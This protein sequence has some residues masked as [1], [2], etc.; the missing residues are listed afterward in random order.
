[1]NPTPTKTN[2]QASPS[3]IN[4]PTPKIENLTKTQAGGED[5]IST[6][7]GKM[8]HDK[9]TDPPQT[10]LG[11]PLRKYLTQATP[12]S[13]RKHSPSPH[14]CNIETRN[15]F[16]ALS[17]EKPT[18]KKPKKLSFT[19]TAQDHNDLESDSEG[20]IKVQ[21]KKTKASFEDTIAE[22]PPKS[23]NS[24]IIFVI[25]TIVTG[26]AFSPKHAETLARAFKNHLKGELNEKI[27]EFTK[28]G[29]IFQIRKGLINKVKSF[30]FNNLGLPHLKMEIRENTPRKTTNNKK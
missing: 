8:G 21:G 22:S 18:A 5:V 13:K 14:H 16:A 17:G 7:R 6:P 12:G 25:F 15:S 26:R 23:N 24:G 4:L 10:P 11:T 19:S 9:L 3:Q 30:N 27:A 29:P 28:M 20:F 2:E 1:M